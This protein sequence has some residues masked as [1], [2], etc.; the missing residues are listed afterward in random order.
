MLCAQAFEPHRLTEY[1]HDTAGAD[2]RAHLDDRRLARRRRIPRRER[3]VHLREP[4]AIGVHLSLEEGGVL[5]Q[6]D[7]R[8]VAEAVDPAHA[9]DG[10]ALDVAHVVGPRPLQALLE[11]PVGRVESVGVKPDLKH[12]RQIVCA[13]SILQ[14]RGKRGK[15]L[16]DYVIEEA[17]REEWEEKRATE[18]YFL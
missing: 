2:G 9:V 5:V 11:A 8:L 10:A 4:H 16:E 3:G 12:A 17:S 15:R 18:R 6:R 1:L 14:E 7:V 13:A